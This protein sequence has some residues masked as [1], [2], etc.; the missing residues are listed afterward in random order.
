[1][2]TELWRL[3][4]FIDTIPPSFVISF[5][6]PLGVTVLSNGHIVWFGSEKKLPMSLPHALSARRLTKSL[7]VCDVT[8]KHL[9][10]HFSRFLHNLKTIYEYQRKEN[11]DLVKHRSLRHKPGFPRWRH[12]WTCWLWVSTIRWIWKLIHAAECC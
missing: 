12:I 6:F 10:K 11:A 4:I 1:M 7:N 9:Q 3:Y 5:K 2:E 8:Y